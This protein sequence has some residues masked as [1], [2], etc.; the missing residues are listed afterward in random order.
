ML[1]G[2]SGLIASLA[3]ALVIGLLT[4]YLLLGRRIGWRALLP[5][6]ALTAVG[7]ELLGIWAAIYMPRAMTDSAGSYGAIGIALC[8]LTWLWGFAG[9][10]VV[11]AVYGTLISRR[12]QRG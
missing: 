11:S 9:V 12:L 8:L 4:P 5:Q 7:I 3:G 10:L 1:H 2:H 6:A